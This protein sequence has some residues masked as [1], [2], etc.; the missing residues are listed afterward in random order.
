M[1]TI[2][3]DIWVSDGAGGRMRQTVTETLDND[4]ANQ[5]TLR[6]RANQALAAN[7]AYLALGTPTNAQVA[8]QVTRL[9]RETN[10]VIRLLVGAL[11]DI[12]DT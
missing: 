7:A 10:A 1:A 8:A 9:T 4:L 11:D 6:D 5:A 2:T 12:S 3:Y